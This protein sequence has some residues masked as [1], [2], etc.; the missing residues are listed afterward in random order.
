MRGGSPAPILSFSNVFEGLCL[1]AVISLSFLSP[2][3][4]ATENIV[5]PALVR[6]LVACCSDWQGRRPLRPAGICPPPPSSS[7]QKPPPTL[8]PVGAR[9]TAVR[10]LGFGFIVT[11]GDLLG[12]VKGGRG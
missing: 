1:T 6:S 8:N 10:V 2:T 3:P 5:E 11:G 12:V 7:A 9:S 4:L